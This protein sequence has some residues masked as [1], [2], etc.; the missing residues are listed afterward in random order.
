MLLGPTR[1]WPLMNSPLLPLGSKL[2][3]VAEWFSQPPK[4]AGDDESVASFVRRH[5]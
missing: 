2:G 4:A 3:I 1:I 5:F